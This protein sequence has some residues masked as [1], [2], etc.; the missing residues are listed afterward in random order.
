M[1]NLGFG[2]ENYSGRRSQRSAINT[3]PKG[4]SEFDFELSKPNRKILEQQ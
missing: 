4:Y 1:Q 3:L 2:I